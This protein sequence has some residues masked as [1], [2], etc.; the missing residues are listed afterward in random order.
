MGIS[1][2]KRRVREEQAR[3]A[4]GVVEGEAVDLHRAAVGADAAVV[5]GLEV[6]DL[7]GI[8]QRSATTLTK[9]EWRK[10]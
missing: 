1:G 8:R 5:A 10:S 7:A 9:D 6:R 4:V 3:G 2:A